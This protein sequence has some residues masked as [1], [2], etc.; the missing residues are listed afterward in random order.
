MLYASKSDGTLAC[1]HEC[2]S[3]AAYGHNAGN[4]VARVRH[5]LSA[6]KQNRDGNDCTACKWKVMTNGR[7]EYLCSRTGNKKEHRPDG[8]GLG[9]RR[10]RFCVYLRRKGHYGWE[11]V[12]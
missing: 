7:K 5:Y 1:G 2:T 9:R 12:M 6:Q 8:D 4:E 3:N 11:P 10:D